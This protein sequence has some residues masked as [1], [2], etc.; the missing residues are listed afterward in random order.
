MLRPL[1]TQ[2]RGLRFSRQEWTELAA[3]Y[4]FIAMLHIVGIGLFAFYSRS[5]PAM[6]GLG[7]AAYLLGLRHAFDSD[8]IAA[9]DDTVRFMLQKGKQPLGVGFFFSLGHSSIV[10]GLTIAIT[11]A[12]G[13]VKHSLPAMQNIGGLVGTLVSGA[14][15]WFMGIL[16]LLVLL[17][18]LSVWGMA[19]RGQHSHD[20]LDELLAKRGLMNRLF[21]GRL[22]K[23]INHSWQM[24]PVGLLFGVGFD[25][26]SSVALLAMAGAASTTALPWQGVISLP[27][28]FAAGMSMMDTTDGVLMCKAYGW[29]FTNPLRKIYYN[30]TTTTISIFVGLAIGTI[31]LAQVLVSVTGAQGA[32]AQT[33]QSIHIASMGYII[34]ASFMLAWIGSVAIWKLGRF[35]ERYGEPH[36]HTHTHVHESGRSH[37]H[38]HYH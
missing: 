32:L 9:V 37:A 24:Y 4:G 3:L 11:L 27:I 1:E 21:R 19:K 6:I 38:K 22:Q 26:A 7:T 13:A 34:V 33:V 10:L 16:N 15:L 12:A 17:D 5:Y 25:T 29:A 8:H 30:I 18:I 28:L 14:F 20:H 36:I 35:Q 2:E 23:V 31:E